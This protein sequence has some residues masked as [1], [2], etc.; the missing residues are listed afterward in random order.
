MSAEEGE[1]IM[2]KLRTM[3]DESEVA[4]GLLVTRS[5]RMD[6]MKA[7]TDLCTE[8]DQWPALKDPLMVCNPT[9]M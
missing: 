7:A 4:E 2:A 1:Q 9:Y 8:L 5:Y 6:R 3:T